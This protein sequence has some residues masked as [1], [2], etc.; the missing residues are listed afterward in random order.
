MVT[1]RVATSDGAH[2]EGGVREFTLPSSVGT[3]AQARQY[4]GLPQHAGFFTVA[5]R[6]LSEDQVVAEG[7]GAKE[8]SGNYS[9]RNK[10]GA[11]AAAERK[12]DR[13]EKDPLHVD[14]ADSDSLRGIKTL[15]LVVHPSLLPGRALCGSHDRC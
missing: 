9:G 3:I 11:G 1:V 12:A 5:E 10:A 6:C 4:L 7:S 2:G 14:V 15:E 13:K 8:E